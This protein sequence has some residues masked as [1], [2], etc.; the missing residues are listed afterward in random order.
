MEPRELWLKLRLLLDEEPTGL[1][2]VSR[3][4]LVQ[5]VIARLLVDLDERL[6]QVENKLCP[7]RTT[8]PSLS[9]M[10]KSLFERNIKLE[11]RIAELE[12]SL[13]KQITV[14]CALRARVAEL[15]NPTK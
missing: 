6:I 2:E 8:M 13:L 5:H 9:D 14:N 3:A 15:E 12:E 10:N 7:E 11:A 4:I 1:K